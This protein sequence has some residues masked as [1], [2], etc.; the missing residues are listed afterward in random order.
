[1]PE[2]DG[3]EVCRRIREVSNVPIIFLTARGRD[4]EKLKGLKLGADDYVTKPFS[5]EL[6]EARIKSVLRRVSW[7]PQKESVTAYADS[8]LAVDLVERRL[9][10]QG[11]EV[12]L[13]P[14]EFRLLAHLVRKGGRVVSRRELVEKAWGW[15][16]LDDIDS[17]RVYISRLRGKIEKN[18]SQPEYIRTQH[19]VG[20]RFEMLN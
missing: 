18:P 15:Q 19:G 4:V 6:L 5:L 11:E 2:M 17:V 13:T 10:V 14:T 20:Y 3:W 8:Y 9:L 7:S 1:M 16:T 12:R